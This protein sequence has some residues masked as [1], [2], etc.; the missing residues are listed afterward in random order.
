MAKKDVFDLLEE[1][2]TPDLKKEDLD[3]LGKLAKKAIEIQDRI[4]KGQQLLKDLGKDHERLVR[5]DI[6]ELLAEVGLATVKTD[7]GFT[8]EVKR[9][10]TASIPATRMEEAVGWLRKNGLDDIVKSQVVLDFGKGEIKTQAKAVT[11]LRS[12]GFTPAEKQ[13][14]HPQ[15][16]KAFVRECL[17]DGVNIP[18]ETFGVFEF[19]EAKIKKE[20]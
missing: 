20:S 16:L 18:M 5:F 19:Q 4:K 12:K 6:P 11:L 13:S 17:E 3:K 2:E 14:I 10:L 8:I 1:E 7:Q 15:T 9:M